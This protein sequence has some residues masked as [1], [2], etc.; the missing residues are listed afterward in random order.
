M[1]SRPSDVRPA[2]CRRCSILLLRPQCVC[3]ADKGLIRRRE[4]DRYVVAS[5]YAFAD[6][7]WVTAHELAAA[8]AA[9]IANSY[10]FQTYWQNLFRHLP[11]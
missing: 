11:C 1:C 3:G 8:K 10:T 6:E 4:G 9:S 7:W 2:T 5:T